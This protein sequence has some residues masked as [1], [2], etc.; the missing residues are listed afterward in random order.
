VGVT[1]PSQEGIKITKPIINTIFGWNINNTPK[2]KGTNYP[3]FFDILT[4]LF[5]SQ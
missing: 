4:N 3:S 5:I 2:I 1:I